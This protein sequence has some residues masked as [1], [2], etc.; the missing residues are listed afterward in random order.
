MS[1][2]SLGAACG[3]AFLLA[4][5]ACEFIRDFAARRAL[6]DLPNERSLHS[7]PVPRLGGVG[8][9][10]GVW[11]VMGAVVVL[12]PGPVARDVLGWFA[13]SLVTAATGLIDDLRPVSASARLAVQCAIALGFTLAIGPPAQIVLAEGVAL[14]LP[15]WATTAIWVV[16]IVGVLNIYNFMDGMDGLAGAQAIGAGLAAS[17]ALAAHGHVDL[18]LLAG[19]LAAASAGFFVH[20]VGPAR[21]FMGDAGSTMLGFTFAALALSAHARPDPL[22]LPVIPLALAPFL[23]DGTFTLLRRASRGEAVWKAHRTHLYQRAVTSGLSHRDV[24]GPYTAWI[25]AAAMAAVLGAR[26]GGW[27]MLGL[28]GAMLA[29]LFAAFCWVRRIESRA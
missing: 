21:I 3:A 12:T 26:A 13:A 8:I 2:T 24:L 14:S 22:P 6:V 18:A 4:L 15:V 11:A 28:G 27:V 10:I 7:L 17:V 1:I 9:A 25:G 29:G 20:N 16:W 5:V 19:L 23:L